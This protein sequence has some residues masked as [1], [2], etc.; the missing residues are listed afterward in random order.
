MLSQSIEENQNDTDSF[1]RQEQEVNKQ[2]R[3]EQISFVGSEQDK[4]IN[5]KAEKSGKI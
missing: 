5:G 3:K 1:L 2:V 4:V